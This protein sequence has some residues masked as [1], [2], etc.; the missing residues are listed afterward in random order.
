MKK[1]LLFSLVCLVIM[2]VFT[3]PISQVVHASPTPTPTPIPTWWNSS[4]SYRAPVVISNS[5]GPL[6]DYQV[7]VVV[8]LNAHMQSNYGDVRF[9]DSAT[10]NELS[11]WLDTDPIDAAGT[12][13][14]KVPSIPASGTATIYMYYG[15]PSA[16]TTSNIHNTF[17]WGDDFSNQTWTDNNLNQWQGSGGN[18]S[19]GVSNGEY[20]MT[21]TYAPDAGG[22]NSSARLQRLKSREAPTLPRI[23]RQTF[24][25]S[26]EI[27]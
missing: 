5:G 26:P 4:W 15:N 17:I 1:K 16:S 7:K 24:F 27:T 8:A 9:V 2:S 20:D 25:H 14:V 6:T 21:G 22:I 3:I 13:W 19:Q 11:Y 18:P 23:S 10:G 12:F